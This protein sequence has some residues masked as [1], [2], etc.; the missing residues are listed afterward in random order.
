VAPIPQHQGEHHAIEN[1]LVGGL[2][3]FDLL[4]GFV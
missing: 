3:A 4:Q 1:S 2:A